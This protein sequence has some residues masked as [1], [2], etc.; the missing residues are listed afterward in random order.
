MTEQGT[1]K[2]QVCKFKRGDIVRWNALALHGIDRDGWAV[3][4][5]ETKNSLLPI[6]RIRRGNQTCSAVENELERLDACEV[7]PEHVTTWFPGCPSCT[8]AQDAKRQREQV[9]SKERV[10][11]LI[12][13]WERR[14]RLSPQTTVA[15]EMSVILTNVRDTIAALKQSHK[16]AHEREGPHCSTCSCPPYQAPEPAPVR[17]V[18]L[19]N[20]RDHGYAEGYSD[21][22][23]WQPIETA[24]V[25]M[26]PI[27][28][29]DGK[30]FAAGHVDHDDVRKYRI[31]HFA[32]SQEYDWTPT[33]WMPLPAAPSQPPGAGQ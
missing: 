33:H 9:P 12:A 6:Y 4:G 17:G 19:V 8:W 29:T 16:P 5:L 28:M 11:E 23:R 20:E 30:W 10:A 7:C 27:L 15:T 14:L 31:Y 1:T 3:Q 32:V 21:A 18:D 24:P 26:D 13:D 2:D 22:V 25:Q